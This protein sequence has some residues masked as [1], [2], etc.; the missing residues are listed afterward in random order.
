MTVFLLL[1]GLLLVVL[2]WHR[3]VLVLSTAEHVRLEEEVDEEGQVGG[4]H[5]DSELE[6]GW[7]EVA[8]GIGEV[9]QITEM[10]E[11]GA[12][13]DEL[14]DLKGG[15]GLRDDTGYANLHRAEEVVRVHEGVDDKVQIDSVSIESGGQWVGIPGVDHGKNVMVPVEEHQWTLAENEE[16]GVDE[17]EE[18]G[19]HEEPYPIAIFSLGEV[20]H[21]A[22]RGN[23]SLVLDGS[24]ELWGHFDG[25]GNGE[26]GE[27]EVPD[28][29]WDGKLEWLTVA[30][31][32][33]SSEHHHHVE[34]RG[35]NGDIK[36]IG[37]ELATLGIREVLWSMSGE[38]HESFRVEL[39]VEKPL[40]ERMLS[41]VD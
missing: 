18:F 17:F 20:E 36:V 33:F 5:E 8:V 41:H 22:V 9:H 38:C 29:E 21:F 11:N 39:D 28:V 34:D 4:V 3:L 27:N 25:S 1:V 16:D 15:D 31:Q 7:V 24:E 35:L 32:P 26:G 2:L 13:D 12:R 40:D 30:H 14:E 23:E 6:D 19:G 10:G 37:K